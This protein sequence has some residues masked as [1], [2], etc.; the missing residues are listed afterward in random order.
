MLTYYKKPSGCDYCSLEEREE[1]HL[2]LNEGQYALNESFSLPLDQNSNHVL[3]TTRHGGWVILSN[4]EFRTFKSKKFEE[5]PQ[6]FKKLEEVGIVLTSKSV[7][8]AAYD[9][10]ITNRFLSLPTAYHVIAITNKCNFN[11]IYC[12]P[13]ASPRKDEMKEG[14]AKK[15]LDFIFSIPMV[16]DCQIILEGGE[17]LLK[18]DLIK[19]LYDGAKKRAKEKNLKL[20]FSFTTNLSLMTE[21]IAEEL[22]K[23]RITPCVSLDGP[24]E[25]HDKQRPFI[26]GAGSHNK[27]IYWIN[28]LKTDYGIRIQ[29]I[30]VITNIS[31]KYGPGAIID[32]YLKIGQDTVFFKPLRASGRALTNL[33]ELE[34]KSEDFYD[35]WE[36]GIEHCLSLNK[37]G[38]KVRE[39]N[40][41]Y[42]VGNLLSPRRK[43]M[44]H[45]RPCGAGI[46]ILS[47][48]CDG[49]INGCDATRGQGF[50][51]LGHV[52]N[53]DYPT[54]RSKALPLVALAS[55]LI[56]IC[57]SCPFMAYCGTCLADTFGKENSLYPKIPRSFQC[58]WQKMAFKYIFKK[59]SEN[60]EDAQ[61]LREW[62]CDY[63]HSSN[64]KTKINV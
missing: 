29:A 51:D 15:V 26:S 63:P 64:P 47:Y 25:L 28:K 27:V 16:N 5:S 31:L 32:E 7:K 49:T 8:K 1:N 57:S 41:I 17:P 6:L 59:F 21:K 44:C 2:F 34:M 58:Q 9:L 33:K 30:P 12:H 38:I 54:I 36:R 48:N 53:D 18:W 20:G 45:R 40:T 23:M 4:N 52:D 46:S 35:F 60:K 10:G 13:D 61:I 3:I 37:K 11:C 43:S 22:V 55:D 42:L 24:K 62:T 56:P 39:R 19:F 50:L 14:T